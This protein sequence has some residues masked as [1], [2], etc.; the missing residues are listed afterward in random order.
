MTT[1][2][3]DIEG[4]DKS[5]SK[6]LNGLG[7]SV[8]KAS[9]KFD[10]LKASAVANLAE[11][12]M[13][14]G[15]MFTS[16]L[17]NAMS[18]EAATDKLSAQLGLTGEVSK[19][20]GQIAGDLYSEA[21][22]SSIE[23]VS[24]AL[25]AVWDQ[26]LID[27]GS[28][29]ADIKQVAATAMDFATTFEQDIGQVSAAVGQMLKTG[30]AQN[31]TEAFDILTVGF[32]KGLDKSGDLLDTFNEYGTQ[33]R[34]LGLDGSAAMGLISQGL[35]AGARDAD[36]VAD[37]IKEFSIRAIDGTK[38]TSEAFAQ[39]GLDGA[40][41][42]ADIAAGGPK[43]TAALQ[44]V[45]DRLRGMKDPVAQSAAAVGL[46]GTQ[47][48]DLGAALFALDPSSAVAGLGQVTGAAQQMGATL[49]DNAQT[50]V[51]AFTRSLE[52]A[53]VN[54]LGGQ[55][56][57]AIQNAVSWLRDN[58]G[59]ALDFLGAVINQAIV[60]ALAALGVAMIAAGVKMAQG[61]IMGMGPIAPL[62]AAVV[63]LAALIIENWDQIVGALSGA[64]ETIKSVAKAGIDFLVGVWNGFV[65]FFRDKVFGPVGRFASTVFDGAKNA[66]VAVKDWI[67]ARW[68]DVVNFFTSIPEKI[69]RALG[70]LG[71]AIGDAFKSALNIAI[72]VINWFIDRAN[73]VIYAINLV[74]PFDDIPNIPKLKRLHEGGIVPGSPG[75]ER[76]A[77]LEA[78]ETVLP[79]DSRGFGGTVT[80]RLIADGADTEMLRLLRRMV[81]I[82]GAGNV[83]TAFGRS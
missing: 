23:D 33:F 60:P 14:A 32:Q 36:I 21:Y 65:G 9:K 77:I 45:L 59:P 80:V 44:T 83:Q 12:G 26:G 22:G 25:R 66:V 19:K 74:N 1:L 3:F 70:G 72:D 37:A 55:V 15:S 61:W 79:A 68:T 76:L 38:A 17:Q 34:K 81:R 20:F 58:F 18:F 8:D 47:A 51:T 28:A 39:L 53:F 16:A 30:M 4:N 63:A 82:E 43:A 13:Q 71:R 41:M 57:P 31:A 5:G 49:A 46:F 35:Q 62:I 11:A 78:G 50:K 48:E 67:V 7:D 64:W 52:T 2:S 75:T 69:G 56:I 54:F 42:A 24:A 10:V 29:T 40:Q 27:E 73:D 6:A